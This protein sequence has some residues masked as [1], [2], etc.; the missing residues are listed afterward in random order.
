MTK[1]A[2]KQTR[3]PDLPYN[4]RNLPF[5]ALATIEG[6]ERATVYMSKTRFSPLSSLVQ[7]IHQ[8][9]HQ[10][11]V[12]TYTP[13]PNDL[14]HTSLHRTT[15]SSNQPK[16]ILFVEVGIIPNEDGG[17]ANL[18]W[19]GVCTQQDLE[20]FFVSTYEPPTRYQGN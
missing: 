1:Q 4:Q 14:F 5:A 13:D 6:E 11:V 3:F 20:A 16:D 2:N 18:W 8:D 10:F 19:F 15:P 7:V 12:L 9:R 17:H